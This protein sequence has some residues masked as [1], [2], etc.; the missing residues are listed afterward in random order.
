M[1][2]NKSEIMT[3]AWAIYRRYN[4]SFADALRKA[5]KEAKIAALRYDVYGENMFY[6][7]RKLLLANATHEEA[8]KCEWYNKNSYD[9]IEIKVAA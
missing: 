7:Q 2:Y 5:W 6:G 3:R 1:K 9:M 8:R 4:V